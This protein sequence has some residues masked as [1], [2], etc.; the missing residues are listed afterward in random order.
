MV[1]PSNEP[2]RPADLP[3]GV[4]GAFASARRV[5][6]REVE[7]VLSQAAEQ[8]VRALIDAI[9]A[10]DRVFVLGMGR[11]KMAVDAFATRLMHMGLTAHIAADATTPAITAGDLLIAC[12]GSGETSVVVTLARAATRA[13]ARV[14]AVT[15][16]ADSTLA[17][18]ADLVVRLSEYGQ[19]YQPSASSQFVGT[20]FEQGA[21]LF[22]DCL[23]LVME[24]SQRLDVRAMFARHT[25]LE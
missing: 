10:A 9:E 17:Q 7:A 1:D 8:E 4:D 21:F 22:F 18:G 16:D 25:N 19:N 20:L 2:E 5:V 12:S 14:A 23:V 13:G 11:S 6:L 3:V 15:G 24:G